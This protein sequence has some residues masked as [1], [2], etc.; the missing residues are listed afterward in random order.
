MEDDDSESILLKKDEG[1]VP[2][3]PTDG[4]RLGVVREHI[5]SLAPDPSPDPTKG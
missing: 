5:I 1:V 3:Q 4:S 2:D